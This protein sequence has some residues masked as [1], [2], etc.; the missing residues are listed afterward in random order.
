MELRNDNRTAQNAKGRPK[1][2]IDPIII[3]CPT[4]KY[5]NIFL[6]SMVLLSQQVFSPPAIQSKKFLNSGQ[7]WNRPT[8]ENSCYFWIIKCHCVR[9]TNESINFQKIPT[10]KWS[11]YQTIKN[12]FQYSRKKFFISIYLFFIEDLS[13]FVMVKMFSYLKQVWSW[14]T[15]SLIWMIEVT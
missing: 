8:S 13:H 12:L 2:R 7:F 15:F 9:T 3:M 14:Y 11:R 5:K 1:G 6:Y 4:N 10:L